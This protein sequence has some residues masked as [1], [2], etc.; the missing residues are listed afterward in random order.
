[1]NVVAYSVRRSCVQLP[2]LGGDPI[3]EDAVV[4]DDDQTAAEVLEVI[5]QPLHRRQIEVVGRLVEEEQ[6]RIGQE[7]RRER[8]PHPPSAREL[9]ERAVLLRDGE[10]EAGEHAAR[11]RLERV[12][13]VELQVMLQLARAIEQPLHLRIGGIDRGDVAVEPV[14]LLA[15]LEEVA[16]RFERAIE[17]RAL[18]LLRSLLRQIAESGPLRQDARA[19]LGRDL[20]EHDPQQRRLAGAVRPDERHPVARADHPVEIV[21]EHARADRV[22]DVV[23]PNHMTPLGLRPWRDASENCTP[24]SA[25]SPPPTCGTMGG[26]GGMAPPDRTGR[27]R[28]DPWRRSYMMKRMFLFV[29]L[30]LTLGLVAGCGGDV[31]KQIMSNPEMKTKVMDAIAANQ[32]MAG[33]LMDRLMASDQTKT[34]V[35]DK[36]M[37]NGD[38]TQAMMTRMAQNQTMVDGIM[39]MA[40]QDSTMRDHV[41]TLAKG[42]MMMKK[43]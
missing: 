39:N 13:V 8:G 25:T 4:R 40:V 16:V 36:V 35:M 14:Q 24:P 18:E 10:A 19:A 26:A 20:P 31:V 37:A 12:L 9:G 38:M 30:A 22:A 3:E 1:M 41:M 32:D 15:H 33:E 11:L 7:E 42:M 28:P 5:L 6:R 2:N 21:E 27:A 17:H 43:R 34:L 23:Q 29:A